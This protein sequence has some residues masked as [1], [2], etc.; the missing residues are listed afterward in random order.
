MR[1]LLGRLLL[2]VAAGL[3]IYNGVTGIMNNIT[4]WNSLGT[5]S[6]EAIQTFAGA[7]GGFAAAI[8]SLILALPAL[9]GLIRGK[10]GFWMMVFAIMEGAIAGYS[11]YQTVT[12]GTLEGGAAIWSYILT[13][14]A[15]ACY[16]LGAFFLLIRR[17]GAKS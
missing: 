15:P 7:I 5:F 10:C 13:I 11:I 14:L 17:R 6:W 1:R 8:G 4:L 3:L 9:I 12:A 16:V 2:G